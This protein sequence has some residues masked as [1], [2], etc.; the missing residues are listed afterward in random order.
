MEE[1]KFKVTQEEAGMRVDKCIALRL[2]EG[3]SR[4]FVKDLIDKKL[5]KVNGKSIKPSYEANEGD[6][7]LAAIPPPEKSDLEPEDIP[8]NVIYEDEWIIVIDKPAG[9]VVHPGAGNRK[10]T[11]V[12]ALL[13]YSEKLADT[14]DESRPGIVHRLDKDTSGIIVVAKNDRALR[15]LSK[16]FQKRAVKKRYAA[17]VKGRLELDNGVVEL[18]LARH[19]TDRKKMAVE[20][21]RG[22]KAKTV[23]HVR[24][25]FKDFTLLDIELH[26]GRTHQIRVHMKHIGHPVLGDITYGRSDGVKR[27]ALHAQMLGFTHPDTGE[28]IEFHSPIPKDMKEIIEKGEI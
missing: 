14:G 21:A 19:S 22:K 2:G 12:N 5:V 23:Y 4:T 6:R 27:Q 17:I 9:M 7:I 26:T 13:H 3:Y 20:H 24:K 11:L 25:R 28:Y 8:L 15:S 16:Q 1:L 18:P 10:G